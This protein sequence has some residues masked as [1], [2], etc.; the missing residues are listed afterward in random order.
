MINPSIYKL[1]FS[2]MISGTLLLACKHKDTTAEEEPDV[3][4]PVTVTSIH[5]DPL[6]EF[7]ELNATSTFLQKSYVKSNLTGY[8]KTV[9]AHYGNFVNAGQVLFILKTKESDALGNTVNQLDPGFKF[10]GVNSIRA[11]RSGYITELSHQP[12][13]YVQDGEQLAVISDMR[14]FVF[15]M[16]LPYEF[17]PYVTANKQVE[18]TLPDGERITGNVQMSMPFMDSLSQTQSVAIKVNAIQKIPQNLVA[19]VRIIKISKATASSLPKAA[20]LSNETQSE[21]WVMKIIDDS[22]AVKVPVKVGIQTTD[23]IEILSPAFLPADKIILKGNY[24]L[25]D[26][27]KIKIEV[28]PA[29]EEK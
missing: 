18:L 25:S 16:N 3:R 6:Q 23:K 21:Y 5:Y 13:D 7:I 14:S 1:F 8:I 2:I 29:A 27:A 22:T 15:L 9:N 4:T 20:V 17:K 11:G 24:G 28:P 10:S 12:G 26:T 19:R